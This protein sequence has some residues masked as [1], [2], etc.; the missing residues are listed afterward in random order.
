ML[1]YDISDRKIILRFVQWLVLLCTEIHAYDAAL[2]L[3]KI[4]Y[5][6]KIM[7]LHNKYFLLVVKFDAEFIIF[8]LLVK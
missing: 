8:V 7:I 4:L 5:L 6:I 1:H 3:C 2:T